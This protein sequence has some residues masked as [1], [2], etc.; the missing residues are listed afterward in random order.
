MHLCI[1]IG[2][3]LRFNSSSN[4]QCPKI[5]QLKQRMLRRKER[6]RKRLM[7]IQEGSPPSGIKNKNRHHRDRHSSNLSRPM[8][9]YSRF[10]DAEDDSDEGHFGSGP[11][12]MIVKSH[13]VS[14]LSN[15]DHSMYEPAPNLNVDKTSHSMYLHDEKSSH[16]NSP[17]TRSAFQSR[18]LPLE[19]DERLGVGSD[20]ESVVD[21][22]L[23][24][25]P[26]CQRS[27]A[28]ATH[29][30]F[31]QIFDNNGV[32]KCIAMRNKKRKVY[33]SAKVRNVLFHPTHSY[34]TH[35]QISPHFYH[36]IL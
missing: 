32:P 3:L 18:T 16:N 9:D 15:D 23:I 4:P 13:E 19:L 29:E 35:L 33:N 17:K 36:Y 10:D 7:Q 20:T 31:C 6:R 8:N 14:Y 11:A 2:S 12:T 25:C 22:E 5:K 27:S 21:I 1:A 24:F 26:H 30:R 28:P 34:N